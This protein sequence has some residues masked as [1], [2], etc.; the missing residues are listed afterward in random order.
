MTRRRSST[1]YKDAE[2]DEGT[3]LAVPWWQLSA[4]PRM[5]RHLPAEKLAVELR[6]RGWTVIE[7]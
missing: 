1:A 4:Q 3:L 6:R 7:P 2:F 5:I